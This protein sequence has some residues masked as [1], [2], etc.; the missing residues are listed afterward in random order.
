MFEYN[1]CTEADNNI[2]AKQCN[3]LE[4][5]VPGIKKERELHDV[6]ESLICVYSLDGK[7][8]SV[9]ND[10]TVGAVYIKSEVD[11]TPYFQ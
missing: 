4:K 8:I 10:E 7:S 11:L 6:D 5:R 9:L 1:I 3:A 2:Y